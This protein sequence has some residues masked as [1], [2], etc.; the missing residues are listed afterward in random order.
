MKL[1]TLLAQALQHNASDLHLSVGIPPVCRINGQLIHLNFPPC[2]PQ[3][4]M[5]MLQSI[6]TRE[7]LA[8]LEQDG[9][10]DFSYMPACVEDIRTRLSA[11][12]QRGSYSIAMRILSQQIP[13]FEQLGLPQKVAEDFCRLQHGLVLV[14]GPTGTGKTTTIASMLDWINHNRA[15]HVIT[16]EDPIEYHHKHDL[17][18]IHQRETGRDTQSFNT[19]L[20]AA[21]RQD[22]DI[23]F[24]GEM[25]DLES[26][27]IALTAAETGHLVF[28]TLHT[29]GAAKAIDRI[30]DV[31]PQYQQAQIRTQ[32]SMVL[33]GTISQQLVPHKSG[34]G[35]V[36]ATE[37][38]VMTPAISNLIRENH[39]AQI[40]NAILT[41]SSIGMHI[42][43]ADLIRLCRLGAITP[44]D[45]KRFAVFPE[46][47]EHQ[48]GHGK[49]G[50]DA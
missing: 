39:V 27:S 43:D 35:R 15:C 23:I 12:R 49:G 31:F 3:D 30:I 4:I 14:T 21:L 1:D 25:R 9:E 46:Y 45:A 19:A 7:E 44:L 28:S 22:P 33:R 10:I 2:T 47:M 5:E 41:G 36:L 6:L 20:R 13:T 26:I 24:I 48:L 11:Y 29:I 17:S 32:L 34:T 42:M 8:R 38:M 40:S 37:V 16:I 50:K 18:M